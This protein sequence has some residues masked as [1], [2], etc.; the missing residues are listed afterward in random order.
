[1]KKAATVVLAA[2]LFLPSATIPASSHSG[3]L[4][5]RGCHQQNGIRHSHRGTVCDPSPSDRTLFWAT[6]GIVVVGFVIYQQKEDETSLSFT[7]VV[8]GG[9]FGF[10]VQKYLGEGTTL[11]FSTTTEKDSYG[12][13]RVLLRWGYQYKF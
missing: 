10:A 4:D 6:A 12:Q 7:P 11:N 1:M 9:G 8:N 2:G 5:S 13:D 3:G